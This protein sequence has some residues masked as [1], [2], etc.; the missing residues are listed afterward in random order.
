MKKGTPWTLRQI[1][2][3]EDDYL[4]TAEVAVIFNFGEETLR[5]LIEQGEF[6]P[7]VRTSPGT[8]LH[9]WRSVAFY[10]LKCDLFRNSA[11][12]ST[13]KKDKSE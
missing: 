6:P 1:E 3:P 5:R 4:T 10:R 11:P 2:A 7:P 13:G 12:V 9:D 8:T